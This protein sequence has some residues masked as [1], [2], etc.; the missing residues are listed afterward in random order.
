MTGPSLVPDLAPTAEFDLFTA[1]PVRSGTASEHR[2]GK[3]ES[4]M[5]MSGMDGLWF[6]RAALNGGPGRHRRRGAFHPLTYRG[7][8][9][10]RKAAGGD[11]GAVMVEFALVLPLLM[12][13]TLGVITGGMVLN[14]QMSV[15]HASREAARYGST[16]A[17]DQCVPVAAC[18]G[19][20]WAQLVRSVGVQRAGGEVDNAGVCV[21]LVQGP[22]TS[23]VA[24]G[25]THTTAGGT[26]ACYVDNSADTAE[27]VQVRISRGDRIEFFSATLPVTISSRATA[28]AE[29]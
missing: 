3:A 23:P 27:R 9:D 5:E 25:S 26:A 1:R 28:R 24:V 8:H 11:T 16:L 6:C 10:R 4:K 13:I 14:R 20:T 22:G 7:L 21:A 18:G 19:L 29:R 12:M 17:I 2:W 15:S